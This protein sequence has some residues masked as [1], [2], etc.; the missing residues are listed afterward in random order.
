MRRWQP[1]YLTADE[2]VGP[3]ERLFRFDLAEAIGRQLFPLGELNEG[4]QFLG[5]DE[6]GVIYVVETWVANFGPW[7]EALIGLVRGHMPVDVA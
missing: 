3:D 1:V 5:I 6:Y 7:S 2:A 4:R